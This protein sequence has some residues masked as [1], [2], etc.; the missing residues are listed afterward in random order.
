VCVQIQKSNNKYYDKIQN[1]INL[2]RKKL[3]QDECRNTV[4]LTSRVRAQRSLLSVIL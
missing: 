1:I 4:S 3:Y 2:Y